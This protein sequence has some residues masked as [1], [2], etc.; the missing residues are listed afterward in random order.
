MQP[1]HFSCC[2]VV[3]G[4]FSPILVCGCTDWNLD[5]LLPAV[6]SHD[7]CRNVVRLSVKSSGVVCLWCLQ[8]ADELDWPQVG[9]CSLS[10]L[11]LAGFAYLYF[12]SNSAVLLVHWFPKHVCLPTCRAANEQFCPTVAR[13]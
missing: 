12:S 4:P 7:L 1:V 13:A 11:H 10:K 6:L 8:A 5:D 9:L 2:D 3:F